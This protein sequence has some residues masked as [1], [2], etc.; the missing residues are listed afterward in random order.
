M[1]LVDR[2]V[3][4]VYC[5]PIQYMRAAAAAHGSTGSRVSIP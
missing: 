1:Q 4:S 3:C 2:D 5:V